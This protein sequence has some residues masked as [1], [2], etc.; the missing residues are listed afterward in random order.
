MIQNKLIYQFIYRNKLQ[1]LYLLI[2]SIILLPIESILLPILYGKLF[3]QIQTSTNINNIYT[4]IINN[5][6]NVNSSGIIW[7]IIIVWFILILF[8][9][10]KF[11]FESKIVPKYLVYI[12]NFIFGKII[13]NNSENFKEVKVGEQ[14][15]RIMELSVNMRDLFYHTISEYIP[16]FIAMISIITYFLF[17]N[18][19]IGIIMLIGTII[20]GILLYL[21]G[22]K[23]ID[24][25]SNREKYALFINEKLN[26]SFTNLMNIYLNNEMN[27]EIKKNNRQNKYYSKLFENQYNITSLLIIILIIISVIT[28]ISILITSYQFLKNKSVSIS[29][30]ISII[31]ISIYY[32]NY[33]INLS[34]TL[35]TTLSN[36]GILKCSKQFLQ[37]ILMEKRYKYIKNTIKGKIQFQNIYFK[38]PNI[39]NYV[40]HDLNLTIYPNQIIGIVGSSGAGKSTI[41]KLLLRMNSIQKGN[42]YID[43]V[44]IKDID[45]QYL[46]NQINYVNQKTALFEMPVID[47]ILYGNQ[48]ISSTKLKYILKKYDL[49]SVYSGLQKGIYTQAGVQGANLSLGMQKVTIILRSI[50]KRCKIIIFDEPLAGLD[51]KTRNKIIKLIFDLCKNKT[52]IIITHDKEILPYCHKVYD[53]HKL[54]KKI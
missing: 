4:N 31:I 20:S 45:T 9:Y 54:Q 36:L 19:T 43:N 51:E 3:N 35:P 23:I 1:F 5:I 7:L 14:I 42:I 29:T 21:I 33:L 17:T 37:N 47:N 32:L 25:S 28:F 41:M 11:K 52:I 16:T 39:P 53:I 18:K 34:K 15:S 27:N 24:I 49:N 48:H 44:N 26:D 46:R 30:F 12:R 13:K 38:Y 8:Y 50:F 6:K 22:K 40:I 2:I 10:L